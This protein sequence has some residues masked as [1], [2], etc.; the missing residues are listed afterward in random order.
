M[1]HEHT[2]SGRFRWALGAVLMPFFERSRGVRGT[3]GGL[4]GLGP[5][6][7]TFHH[8]IS[9]HPLVAL[10]VRGGNRSV[11]ALKFPWNRPF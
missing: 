4:G 5:L 7:C 11:V 8:P 2:I 6:S 1:R 9:L 10:G 3:G